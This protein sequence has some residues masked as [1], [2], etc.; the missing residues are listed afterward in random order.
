VTPFLQSVRNAAH[1]AAT[2]VSLL[3]LLYQG[4]IFSLSSNG[5]DV[6]A[7]PLAAAIAAAIIGI[8]QGVDSWNNVQNNKTAAVTGIPTA[9]T[10][11]PT[12]TPAPPPTFV[13]DAPPVPAA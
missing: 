5:V 11:T 7:N 1:A 13:S 3:V 6:H 2:A 9:A 4:V 12:S 8:S 10:S